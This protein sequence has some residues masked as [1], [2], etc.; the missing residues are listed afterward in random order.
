MVVAEKV[1][2]TPKKHTLILTGRERLTLDGICEV[3]RFDEE[4]VVLRTAMGILTVE[5]EGLHVTKL[6][7][8]C[9]EVNVE[10]K[11]SALV[12]SERAERSR[13]F[14]HRVGGNT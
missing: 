2:P 7:L 9:G 13:G 10:G 1:S 3:V 5:G 14:F 12:Y 11:I 8:D 4:S 6:L